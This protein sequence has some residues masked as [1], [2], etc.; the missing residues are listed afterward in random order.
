KNG[1]DFQQMSDDQTLS[2]STEN[3][4]PELTLEQLRA[5]PVPDQ[6]FNTP[7]GALLCFEEACRRR[8][9]E[10]VCVCKNFL[11]EA[12]LMLLNADPNLVRNAEL[13]KRNAVLLERTFRKELTESWPDLKGVEIF[14]IDRQVYI[15]GIV[16]V[17][18]LRRLPDGSFNKL[19]Y[20]VANTAAGWR[21]LNQ[22][23]DDEIEG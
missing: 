23:S 3:D 4:K 12:I 1:Q 22:I 16:I 11:I 8:N 9:I 6:D 21:V 2:P 20:L 10:S 7:E 15:K 17:T 13:R 19:N 5:L 14:F 18:E